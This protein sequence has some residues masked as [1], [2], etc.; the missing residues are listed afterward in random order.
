MCFAQMSKS[1][2]PAGGQRHGVAGLIYVDPDFENLTRYPSYYQVSSKIR[3]PSSHLF[4]KLLQMQSDCEDTLLPSFWSPH[5]IRS[6]KFQG[7]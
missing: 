6:L 3:G 5:P 1:T 2:L 7:N 4:I